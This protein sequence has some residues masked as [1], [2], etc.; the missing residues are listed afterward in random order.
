MWRSLSCPSCPT[1]PPPPSPGGRGRGAPSML[2]SYQLSNRAKSDPKSSRNVRL[3]STLRKGRPVFSECPVA[4]RF[5]M[6]L[7][8]FSRVLT[9]GRKKAISFQNVPNGKLLIESRPQFH[10]RDWNSS[11]PPTKT[12]NSHQ[13][14]CIPTP[15]WKN[16]QP[17]MLPHIWTCSIWPGPKK[18]KL[19]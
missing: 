15:Y 3:Q 1:Y 16:Q 2:E 5:L 9:P 7:E 19:N 11:F 13:H 8:H 17:H 6:I 12:K 4:P 10:L 18:T 14:L